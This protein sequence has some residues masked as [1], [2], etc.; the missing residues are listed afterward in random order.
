MAHSHTRH[1]LSK[2]GLAACGLWLARLAPPA[3]S[4][5]CSNMKHCLTPTY[6]DFLFHLDRPAWPISKCTWGLTWDLRCGQATF[7]VRGWP[8]TYN[9]AANTI[10]RGCGRVASCN[11]ASQ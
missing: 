5:Q 9:A 1:F 10:C 6:S 4:K 8:P 11:L 7:L 2:L 3:Y